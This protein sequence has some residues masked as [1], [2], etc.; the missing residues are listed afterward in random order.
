MGLLFAVFLGIL[1]IIVLA[2]IA[3]KTRPKEEQSTEN[4]KPQLEKTTDVTESVKNE[5]VPHLEDLVALLVRKGIITEKELLDEI[6]IS[7][8]HKEID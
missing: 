6:C 5:E 3:S 1:A 4:P 8:K 2:R 7:T